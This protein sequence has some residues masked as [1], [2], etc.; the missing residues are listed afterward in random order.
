MKHSK[1]MI[2]RRNRLENYLRLRL[3]VQQLLSKPLLNIVLIP[4]VVLLFVILW[5]EKE[6]AICLFHVPEVLLS[7]Y[8]F[9]VAFIAVAIPLL[10]LLLILD[11]IGK[12]TARKDEVALMIAFSPKD[13][14]NG[15]PI[16]MSKKKLKIDNNK[17]TNV[18]IIR[19]EYYSNI[20]LHI[21]EENKDA[22][23]DAMNVRFLEK[24]Q[25]GGRANGKRIVIYTSS[26]RKAENREKL[27]DEEF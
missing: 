16:L 27:Y 11:Y 4:I 10:L 9:S 20:P 1:Y 23:A 15:C 24:I 18:I 5:K 7:A 8:R 25:Y 21:W 3:G 6:K 12:F 19:R 17:K 14:R 26:G 22:I 13:L 2:Q